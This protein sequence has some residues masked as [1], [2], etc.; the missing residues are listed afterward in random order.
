MIAVRERIRC[1]LQHTWLISNDETNL[2]KSNLTGML[3]WQAVNLFRTALQQLAISQLVL[4]HSDAADMLYFHRTLYAQNKTIF[5]THTAHIVYLAYDVQDTE[6][7]TFS[8]KIFSP[9]TKWRKNKTAGCQLNTF[10]YF[11]YEIRRPTLSPCPR[12]ESYKHLV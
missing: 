5:F 3:N 12:Y 8:N 4:V 7:M 11:Q 9:D 10:F 6:L 1:L 2:I